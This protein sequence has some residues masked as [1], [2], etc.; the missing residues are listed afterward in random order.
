MDNISMETFSKSYVFIFHVKYPP[1]NIQFNGNAY[2]LMAVHPLLVF[3][4][5]E[6]G[7]VFFTF[8]NK[9]FFFKIKLSIYKNNFPKIV[10]EM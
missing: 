3:F 5:M 9:Y 4:L 6:S 7:I 2:R 10:I 1:S 8:Y